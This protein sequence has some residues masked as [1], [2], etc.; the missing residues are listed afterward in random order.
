MKKSLNQHLLPLLAT[1]IGV[2]CGAVA[3]GFRV[4]HM[5]TI[6]ARGLLANGHIAGIL[7]G[8]FMLLIPGILLRLSM[9]LPKDCSRGFCSSW[10]GFIGYIIGAL[11]LAYVP[12]RL[13]SGQADGLTQLTGI[14]GLAAAVAVVLLAVS[15]RKGDAGNMIC[16]GI[17]SAFWMLLLL[18][19]YRLWSS[20]SQVYFFGYPLLATVCLMLGSYHRASFAVG[21]GNPRYYT[22][23]R[24]AG[25]FFCLGAV[26]DSY[27]G[28]LYLAAAI[29]AAADN[30]KLDACVAEGD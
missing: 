12:F 5:N 19:Q 8:I 23:F 2:L 18:C 4:W 10:I 16:H 13:L 3:F 24:T 11:G 25:I 28:I 26:A 21:L 29:W 1:V 27:L 17:V 20:E 9:V 6:D 30:L 14:V 22:F 7:A 15:H